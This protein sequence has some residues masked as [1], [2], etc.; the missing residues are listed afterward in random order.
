MHVPLVDSVEFLTGA[1]LLANRYMPLALTL[2]G[3]VISNI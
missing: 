3:A 2:L 1:L